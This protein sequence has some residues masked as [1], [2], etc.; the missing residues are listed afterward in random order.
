MASALFMLRC[1]LTTREAAF[2]WDALSLQNLHEEALENPHVTRSSSFQHLDR[3]CRRLPNWTTS[4]GDGNSVAD[5]PEIAFPC[6]LEDVAFHVCNGM[7]FQ[8]DGV[9]PYSSRQVRNWFNS[10]FPD[11]WI[12]SVG[13]ILCSQVPWSEPI[14]FLFMGIHQRK[15]LLHGSTDSILARFLLPS[16]YCGIQTRC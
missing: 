14:W 13:L 3:N 9:P 12:D 1:G 6:L 5:F 7:W 8:H 2:K 15:R 16:R 4:D 10:Y 11:T